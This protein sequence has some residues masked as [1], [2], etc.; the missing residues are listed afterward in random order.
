MHTTLNK[1]VLEL[2]TSHGTLVSPDTVQYILSKADPE[3]Y[4]K[5]IMQTFTEVP[6]FLT[7]DLLKSAEMNTSSPQEE[8]LADELP[9]TS[10]P[11]PSEPDQESRPQPTEV[12]SESETITSK[13][14]S[15]SR[16]AGEYDSQVEILK[17]IS[18]EST[19]EGTLNDFVK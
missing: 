18:G 6:L 17:D 9:I 7:V 14:S 11:E 1:R 3:N 2:L 10:M 4:V 16:S 5:D 15:K 13:M 19:S 8:S 12:S